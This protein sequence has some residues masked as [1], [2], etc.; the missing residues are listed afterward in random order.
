MARQSSPMNPL[1]IAARSTFRRSMGSRA[2]QRRAPT[3]ATQ[4]RWRHCNYSHFCPQ[5]DSILTTGRSV[6]FLCR[7]TNQNQ[8][9]SFSTCHLALESG[10][11][12]PNSIVASFLVSLRIDPPRE[13]VTWHRVMSHY[14]I[15]H[16]PDC[17]Y[18][19]SKEVSGHTKKRIDLTN[20]CKRT[21]IIYV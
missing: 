17:A 16:R 20:K 15:I 5:T 21:K 13:I 9:H 8:T 14:I 2:R 3:R 18:S 10:F 6:L 7:L 12:F 19:L 1:L 11:C 4:R